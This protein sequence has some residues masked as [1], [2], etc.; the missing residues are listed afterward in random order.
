M[1]ACALAIMANER[2]R[3]DEDARGV[4][5]DLCHATFETHPEFTLES[6][7]RVPAKLLKI[8]DGDTAWVSINSPLRATF[9]VR[10]VGVDTPEMRQP[11]D[12][13]NRDELKR[14]AY[15]ARNRLAQLAT[16]VQIDLA[17]EEKRAPWDALISTNTLTIFAVFG[18]PDK[19]GRA[20]ATLYRGANDEASINEILIQEG[21]AVAYDGGTKS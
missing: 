5:V 17:S 21:H 4:P 20:L 19:Y 14:R 10:L 11:A 15:A 18:P 13:A 9:R 8:Y 12:L 3:S 2:R 16:D 1:G 6:P 7:R